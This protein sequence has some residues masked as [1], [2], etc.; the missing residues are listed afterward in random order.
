MFVCLFC[1]SKSVTFFNK[2]SVTGYYP[3]V[4]ICNLL[5]KK[6]ISSTM[7]KQFSRFR[8]YNPNIYI[9]Y[10]RSKYFRRNKKTNFNATIQIPS[11][12]DWTQHAFEKFE[13][14]VIY[15]LTEEVSTNSHLKSTD[16]FR[17]GFTWT[18]A[19]I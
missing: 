4:Q 1:W 6:I 19:F 7:T 9:K 15:F 16:A 2:D 10:R 13:N 3:V 5:N 11:L 17:N 14:K 18:N 8:W 12:F